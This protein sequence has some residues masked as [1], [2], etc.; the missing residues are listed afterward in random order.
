MDFFGMA[1]EKKGPP[2][3]P[4]RPAAHFTCRSPWDL[5]KV[6]AAGSLGSPDVRSS[7]RQAPPP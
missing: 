6:D 4:R 2:A 1:N 3:G 5:V 7:G